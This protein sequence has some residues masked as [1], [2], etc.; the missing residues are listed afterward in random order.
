MQ[1]ATQKEAVKRLKIVEGHLKKVRQMVEDGEYCPN[2]IQQSTAIQ[3]ALRRVDELLLDAHLHDC[4]TRAIKSGGGDK[5]IKEVL[6][7]FRKYE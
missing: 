5:E 1:K 3:H 6:A 4:V 7:A 2:I